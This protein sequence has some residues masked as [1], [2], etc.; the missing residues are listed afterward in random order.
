MYK[1]CFLYRLSHNRSNHYKKSQKSNNA[2]VSSKWQK[3]P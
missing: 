1:K 2:I 3:I